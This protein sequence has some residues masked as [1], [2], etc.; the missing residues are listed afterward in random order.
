ML[1]LLLRPLD[2]FLTDQGRG[3]VIFT[4]VTE[5]FIVQIKVALLAGFFLALPVIAWQIYRFLQP[6]FRGREKRY[7]VWLFVLGGLLFAVG[8]NFGYFGVLPFGVE[9]LIS[10]AGPDILP[11][12]SVQEY[13]AFAARLMFAFGI[14]FEMPLAVTLLASLGLVDRNFFKRNRRIAILTIFVAAAILTPPDVLTQVM[15][16]VPLIVL[17][18]ISAQIASVVGVSSSDEDDEAEDDADDTQ[19]P[20]PKDQTGSEATED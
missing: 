4:G 1:N 13:F 11:Q 15:L 3:D 16:G 14:V 17:Y 9:F 20:D 7:F 19:N 6:A 18:E 5:P 10:I 12:V 2:V 8:A